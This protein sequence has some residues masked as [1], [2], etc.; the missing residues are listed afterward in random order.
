MSNDSEYNGSQGNRTLS[1]ID[2]EGNIMEVASPI[3]VDQM[4]SGYD[5]PLG[6]PTPV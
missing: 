3:I 2:S 6:S 4:L 1:D 5:H